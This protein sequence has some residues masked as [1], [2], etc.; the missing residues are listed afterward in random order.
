MEEEEEVE[1]DDGEK[2][3]D[4]GYEGGIVRRAREAVC[5]SNSHLSCPRLK[6]VR[7]FQCFFLLHLTDSVPNWL[8][9]TFI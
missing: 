3:V 4:E 6:E 7:D 5:P 9:V 1:E 8:S 2:K